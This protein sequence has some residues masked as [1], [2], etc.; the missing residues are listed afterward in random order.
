MENRTEL[1][2]NMK[3]SEQS[4]I[5][6]HW[7]PRESQFIYIYTSKDPNLGCNSIQRAESTYPVTTILLNHQLSLGEA[8]THL[9]K[10]IRILLKDLDEEESK[11]YGSTPRTLDLRAFSSLIGQITEYAINRVA[12]DWEAYK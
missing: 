11:S 9:A 5:S 3:L 6:K 2:V 7:Y 10:G 4:Y 8:A 1:L 12:N